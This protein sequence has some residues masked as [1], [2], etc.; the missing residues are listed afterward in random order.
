MKR[1]QVTRYHADGVND[2][3][4]S[5]GRNELYYIPFYLP[6][7]PIAGEKVHLSLHREEDSFHGV[8]MPTFP[9]RELHFW[10]FKG[11]GSPGKTDWG[12]YQFFFIRGVGGVELPG[13][14]TSL[15][16]PPLSK[17]EEVLFPQGTTTGVFM[18]LINGLQEH[19]PYCLLYSREASLHW[20]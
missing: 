8:L 2:D 18:S 14:Q 5:N 20:W 6:F 15:L 1:E 4:A 16:F 7:F 11:H 10:N 17:S 19:I 9:P 3:P 12:C 13:N